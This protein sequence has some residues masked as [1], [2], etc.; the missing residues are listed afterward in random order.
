M[1]RRN[2]KIRQRRRGRQLCRH[3][4]KHRAARWNHQ[5]VL[6]PQRPQARTANAAGSCACCGAG[7]AQMKSRA[8]TILRHFACGTAGG[9]ARINAWGGAS[10]VCA[11]AAGS[12]PAMTVWRKNCSHPAHRQ[13]LWKRPSPHDTRAIA[14]GVPLRS[15][16]LV[17]N[18]GARYRFEDNTRWPI[19]P[20]PSFS[21][22][23]G[24]F[25]SQ[26]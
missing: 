9:A 26:N 4:R 7:W 17:R 8:E 2:R 22:C 18:S 14:A 25:I 16:W 5:S 12:T 6:Q 15:P 10:R 11:T 1:T 20:D 24:G 13:P 19:R 21:S 3:C 23:S